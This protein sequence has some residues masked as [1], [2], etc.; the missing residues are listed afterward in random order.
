MRNL[1]TIV[2]FYIF[3]LVCFLGSMADS[4]IAQDLSHQA[5]KVEMKCGSH[6][7]QIS[8]GKQVDPDYPED[9]RQCNHNVLTFIDQEGNSFVS[10][11]PKHFDVSKTPV[12]M[13]CMKSGKNSGF[14]AEIRFSNGPNDCLYCITSNLF[15]EA[16]ERLT[17]ETT[18]NLR[19][20]ARMKK[21]LE[22]YE[23]GKEVEIEPNPFLA[24]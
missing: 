23:A 2:R 13:R 9:S 10:P 7:V 21:Q 6:R 15:S 3:C 17:A 8:C 24:K 1:S 22:L 16:G 19:K 18:D 11:T 4:S 20:L 14:Y 12:S 5:T